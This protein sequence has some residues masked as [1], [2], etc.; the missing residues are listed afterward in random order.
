[1]TVLIL[2]GT[3]ES[4]ELAEALVGRGRSVVSSLAGRVSHPARPA[5]RLRVGGFGG[6]T[7]LAAYLTE[8][9]VAAVVDAT[10]PFATSISVHAAQATAQVG[11]P[12]LRLERPGW[13]SHPCAGSWRWVPDLAAARSVADPLTRRPLLTTGRQSLAIF[14]PWADR[15]VL[16]RVVDPPGFALPERW[17]LITS[18]GPYGY[19]EERQLMQDFGADLLLTKDS[20]GDHTAAKLDAAADLGVPIVVVARPVAVPGVRTVSTVAE[21]VSWVTECSEP[22]RAH[23]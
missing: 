17:R 14:L 9:R 3:A 19:P 21:A 8:Q 5:G 6:V 11:C 18:R 15:E 22:R 20:G 10:H 7:G 4:R 1:M 12:L 13:S 2:G 16:A 23:R